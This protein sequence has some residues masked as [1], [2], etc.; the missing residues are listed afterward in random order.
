[1]PVVAEDGER[2][3]LPIGATD[4]TFHVVA[5]PPLVVIVVDVVL[6]CVATDLNR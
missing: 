6:A 1:M 3:Q 4:R 5:K 2:Q